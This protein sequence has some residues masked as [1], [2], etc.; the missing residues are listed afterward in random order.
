MLPRRSRRVCE[1]VLPRPN[2]RLK[3]AGADRFKGSGVLCPWRGTDFV[4]QPCA[5]GRVARSLSAIPLGGPA[6]RL[7]DDGDNGTPPR[8]SKRRDL[9]HTSFRSGPC[10]LPEPFSSRCSSSPRLGRPAARLSHPFRG[11]QPPEQFFLPAEALTR[12]R[13]TTSRSA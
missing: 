10:A 11:G 5:G 9:P 3:L 1:V 2:K 7:P 6:T 8:I 12:R 13:L 4:P